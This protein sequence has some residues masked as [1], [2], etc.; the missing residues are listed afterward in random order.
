MSTPERL[1]VELSG[2][3]IVGVAPSPGSPGAPWGEEKVGRSAPRR[4][5]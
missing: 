4:A 5:S 3:G 1:A 2:A